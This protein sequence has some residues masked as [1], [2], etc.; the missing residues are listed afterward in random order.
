MVY[1]SGDPVTNQANETTRMHS[2]KNIRAI[3]N[4]DVLLGLLLGIWWIV[5]LIQAGFTE[6]ANDEAYYYMFSKE[7]AWGYFD[8]PPMTAL[9]VWLGGF[10]GGEL[11]VRFFFTLLQPLYLFIL[12]KIVKP[13]AA[14]RREAGLFVLIAAAMPILQLYGFI[15]VPDGPLMFFT[16]LF[17]W[18]Y[19]K[20]TETN[21]WSDALWMGV[22]IAALAYSKY[23]GALVVLFTVLSNLRLLKNPKFYA[24]CLLTLVL[25]VPH[26]A[27]QYQHDWISF[28][29]HLDGRTRDFEFSFVTEYLLNLLAIFNP[30]LFPVFLKGWWKTKGNTPAL[31][32]LNCISAGFILFF[33]ASTTRGYVQPQWEI[34][35]AFGVIAV[36]Y[37]FTQGRER[38]RRYIVRVGQI[39]VVLIALVRIEMI[40]NP[41]GIKFE[42]FDNRTSFG[43]IAAAAQGRPVIFDGNYTDAAKYNFYTGGISYAQPSVY[44]RTSQY[45]LKDDDSA[46]AGKPVV[47]QV[48]G[49]SIPGKQRLLLDNGKRFE[50][51]VSEHFIPVRKI[52]IAFDEL[53]AEVTP[54]DTL[55]LRLTLR[56]PYPYTYRIDGD[57][58]TVSMV[59]RHRSEPTHRYA[60]PVT[61]VLPPHGEIQATADFVVPQLTPRTFQVGFTISNLPASTWFNGKTVKIKTKKQPICSSN[62]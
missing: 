25:I 40:F 61:G 38:L 16:A 39:T 6:L 59:W 12:W 21:R 23:H 10:L 53:P 60:L 48:W 19:K 13:A 27:W 26:L 42:V 51:I 56:N 8:H 14:D 45:E 46:M 30:L 17:L 7:L 52:D 24:G 22:M 49:D 15:A 34:P 47:L 37:Q 41:L 29:Y 4:P 3:K 33:L 58:V 28:R 20:F 62:S 44:Y 1:S 55:H 5:N 36:L 9:L 2:M 43:R 11:G 54:G 35:A 18:F 32:A 57:S 31:R 50:Y